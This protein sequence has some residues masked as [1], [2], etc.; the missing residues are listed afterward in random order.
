MTE[1][2]R[3]E[4]ADSK[5]RVSTL[6]L[7]F[8]LVFVFMLTQLT[9]LLESN[10][11]WET[12]G[13]VLLIFV[14]LFWMYGGY[15][16]LTNQVPPENTH[17]RLLLIAAMAGFMV[18]ALA[19]P[20]AFGD[21]GLAIGLGYLMVVLVHAGLYA[22]SAGR[23]VIR[24]APFNLLGAAAL[25]AASF[26]DGGFRYG[27]WLVP[28]GAQYLAATVGRPP[29]PV[30][31]YVL[32]SFHLVERHGLL[33]I[34]ALGESVVA[35]G[36]GLGELTLDLGS[37]L[38]VVLGVGLA[39]ALWWTYFLADDHLAERALIASDSSSRLRKALGGFFYSYIPMLL[40]VVVLAAGVSHALGHFGER[41]DVTRALLLA[42][43][44][45]LYLLGNVAFRIAMGIRPLTIRAFGGVAALAT[46]FVGVAVSAG[47]Q[48]VSLL[49][50]L[51][52]MLTW[53]MR[54]ETAAISS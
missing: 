34:V 25:I 4:S 49:L 45:A 38:G 33:L 36:F 12:A 5:R 26:V 23:E 41:L 6:E 47:L 46:I 27:L 31:G 28:L 51:V 11:T 16:W 24:F 9:S 40:G 14:V 32:H 21:A 52:V 1:Q 42:G 2:A 29:E 35:V 30:T 8:D 10:P 37:Y 48:L 43:G 7:F 20:G 39:G 13:Q 53:E 17:R 22:E 18:C 15:A 19:A 50:V 44:A 3:E 54:G